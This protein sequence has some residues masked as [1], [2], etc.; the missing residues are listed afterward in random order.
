VDESSYRFRKGASRRLDVNT[1]ENLN[2]LVLAKGAYFLFEH[3][4]GFL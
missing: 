1:T 3:F 2:Q 4:N